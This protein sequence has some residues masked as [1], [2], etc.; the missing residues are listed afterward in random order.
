MFT[1]N[2]QAYTKVWWFTLLLRV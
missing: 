2:Y 1:Y